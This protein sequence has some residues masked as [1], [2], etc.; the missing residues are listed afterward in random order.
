MLELPQSTT[1][2]LQSCMG[3][4]TVSQSIMSRIESESEH[5]KTTLA[6]VGQEWAGTV[7]RLG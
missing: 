4:L 1:D 3:W 6:E 2:T 7:A 5:S